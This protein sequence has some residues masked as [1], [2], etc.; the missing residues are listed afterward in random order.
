MKKRLLCIGLV[1]SLVLS[2]VMPGTALADKG[3]GFE[4]FEAAGSVLG[5]DPGTVKAAGQSGRW[6]VSERQVIGM[7]S[8]C[9][10]A[11]EMFT[12]TYAANVDSDQN[13]TFHGELVVGS[14]VFKVRGKSE[15]GAPTGFG[16]VVVEVPNPYPPPDTIPVEVPV[17]FCPLTTSGTWNLIEGAQ[18]NGDYNTTITVAI[19]TD[20]PFQGH[21]VAVVDSSVSLTGKWRP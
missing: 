18:G 1:V 14:L 5:I 4:E 15:M 8:V 6:I 20:G 16:T 7:M 9:E 10:A 19:A 13:G 17:V 11:P 12:M 3:G 2:I 21:I